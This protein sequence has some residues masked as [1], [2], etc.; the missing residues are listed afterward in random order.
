MRY[1]TTS[2]TIAA[3]LIS[4]AAHAQNLNPQVQVTNDY[5][6][7]LEKS[8]KQSVPLEVPDSLNIFRTS[9]S[10]NV[11]ATPYKGSYEFVPYEI[12]VTPQ[13]PASDASVFY[14]K[15]GA[16][17]SFHPVL[18]AIWNPLQG[19]NKHS[20]TVFEH[21]NGYT[22]KYAS[23]DA[24]PDY[25]GHD[26]SQAIGIEGRWFHDAFTLGYGL[27]YQ[28][29]YTGDFDGNVNFNDF[30]LRGR[31]RSNADA[32]I[33]Y[34]LDVELNQAFD[35][36]VA[37]TGIKA[38]GGFFPNWRLP[39]ELRLDFNIDSDFYENGGYD[40]LF[41]AQVS[42]K[43][44]YEWSV[45]RLAA[46][47]TLSPASDIQ[48][49][50]PDV[51]LTVDLFDDNL[52]AYAFAKGGQLVKSYSDLKHADHWFNSTY[53]NVMKPTLERLNAALGFRGS[54]FKYFQYDIR[55]GWASYSSAPMRSYKANA[56]NA[57]YRDCG[58]VYADYNTWY[59][60][61]DAHWKTSRLNVDANLHYR[62]TNIVPNGNYL[63][64]PEFAGRIDIMYNWYSRIF[65]GINCSGQTAQDASTDPVPG[66]I[67]LGLK[68][69]YLFSKRFG[70]WA[71]VG[72]LLNSK[73]TLSP[74]HM[75]KGV[76]FTAGVSFDLR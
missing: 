26:L 10:Y 52:Q 7:E 19:L 25:S 22:G 32:K 55:G 63:N 13:K 62:H 30:T 57:A 21:F 16:G 3:L 74:L 11:F 36:Q 76:Y 65:A 53:T 18:T 47:V 42:P 33:V 35:R 9:V 38:E 60:D 44:L 41:V 43:A 68:G 49:I 70:V 56:L 72:N 67:D 66:F 12:S 1:I 51:N 6:A 45:V 34:N 69:E 40:N 46:G 23:L 24:R 14:L 29:I 48:W 71:N 17:Y 20:L 4:A 28:G 31:I 75:Q 8:G 2:L 39:F 15:A 5:K 64:L 50:Y 27:D 61:A 58:I 73:I 54:A 59:A 37:Q